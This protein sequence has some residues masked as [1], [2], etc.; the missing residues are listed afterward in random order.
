MNDIIK[1]MLER[2][3]IKKYKDTPVPMELIDQICEAG[4]YAANGR[5]L[6]AERLWKRFM[7]S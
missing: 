6:Q 7:K 5:G 3:S 1:A 2:R 4:K